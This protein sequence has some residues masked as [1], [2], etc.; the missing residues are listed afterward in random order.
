MDLARLY[1]WSPRFFVAFLLVGVASAVFA[2]SKPAS[3]PPAA[4]KPPQAQQQ[5]ASP[6][7]ATVQ[8]PPSNP[9][10]Q[11]VWNV[12]CGSVARQAPLECILEQ[13]VVVQ[14]TGQQLSLVS[15][16]VPGD[17]RQ[18]V[19]LVQLPLGMYLPGG[20]TL[21][22]DEEKGQLVPIQSCDQRACYVGLPV[23]A[24]MLTSLK[25]GQRL[26]LIIQSANRES[27][28]IPHPLSDF[29]DQYQKIQ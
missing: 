16:R 6:T 25:K 21:Q 23:T 22:V 1:R 11:P 7:S 19:M 2:Q 3:S 14:Q 27:I 20:L 9:S 12:R 18:P 13:Q 8:P 29:S 24:E 15:V 5:P 4:G 10:S 17:T 26:N 28:T